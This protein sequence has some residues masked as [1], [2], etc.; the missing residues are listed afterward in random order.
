MAQDVEK[1]LD[2][3]LVDIDDG[4]GRAHYDALDLSISTRY[5]RSRHV[6]LEFEAGL[7]VRSGG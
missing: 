7:F 1:T 2:A 3:V 5:A 4:R 6:L